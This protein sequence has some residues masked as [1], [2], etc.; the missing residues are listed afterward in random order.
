MTD[1]KHKIPFQFLRFTLAGALAAAANYGSRFA[2]SLW[3]SFPV[4][5]V[6][7]YVVGMATAFVIMRQHVFDGRGK[8]LRRQ[9]AWFTIVN[10]L[11]AL[12]TLIISLLLAQWLLPLA[13]V[14]LHVEAIAHFVGVVFPIGTSYLGHRYA[15]FK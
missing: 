7:A 5:I 12:Q 1:F 4:A 13:G 2:F 10:V 3:F 9:V 6:F 15:T 8:P 11:A 14:E